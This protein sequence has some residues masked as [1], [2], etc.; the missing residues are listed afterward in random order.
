MTG[1]YRI[2]NQ[3]IQITSIYGDI[4]ERCMAF[5]VDAK[6]DYKIAT[7]GADIDAQWKKL[8]NQ[9]M[10]EQPPIRSFSEAY[11][12][13]RAIFDN[14]AELM[15]RFNTLVLHGSA[16]ATKGQGFLFLSKRNMLKAFFAHLWANSDIDGVSVLLNNDTSMI[17][18][19]ETETT[20]YSVPWYSG[21]AVV[22]NQSAPLKAI[23]LLESAKKN[24]I[25]QLDFHTSHSVLL[26]HSF[27]P[28]GEYA[29]FQRLELINRL[30]KSVEMYRFECNMDN[31]AVQIGFNMMNR[32]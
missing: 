20:V 3:N 15:L 24:H 8:M 1:T 26:H 7:T 10:A 14:I 25:N 11:M 27:S 17:Y 16:V 4:H 6:P 32:N 23:C 22:G 12:E 2:T 18:L 31:E 29:R 19:S 5:R 13:T 9:D 28:T 30:L 21:R